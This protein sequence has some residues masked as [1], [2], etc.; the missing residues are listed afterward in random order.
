MG[1]ETLQMLAEVKMQ[2]R[3]E[4]L[5]HNQTKTQLKRCFGMVDGSI[6]RQDRPPPPPSS[7]RSDNN[8]R[9]SQVA[10]TSSTPQDPSDTASNPDG[11]SHITESNAEDDTADDQSPQLLSS[12]VDQFIQQGRMDD[13]EPDCLPTI[14]QP[15]K[16]S[17]EDLFDFSRV[18]WVPHHQ[19]TGQRSLREELEVY[20]LLDTDFP[21]EEGVEVPIDDTAG[22]ILTLHV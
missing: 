1:K 15:A 5:A 13:V 20:N 22:D 12:I 7:V 16:I 4:H 3:D 11:S 10:S 17:L 21:G 18:D 2:V 9:A 6:H 14:N 19:R 8:F